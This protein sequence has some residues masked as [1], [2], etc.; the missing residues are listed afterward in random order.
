MGRDL[1]TIEIR[2]SVSNHHDA[3]DLADKALASQLIEE[4]AHVVEQ[5]K[6]QDLRILTSGL[7]PDFTAEREF[8]EHMRRELAVLTVDKQLPGGTVSV[9]VL[10]SADEVNKVIY[11]AWQAVQ[12][13]QAS[14]IT[15]TRLD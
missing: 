9:P 7:Q 3:R 11:A 1:F 2:Y 12:N 8:T 4:L 14:R 10:M 6:Y 15:D 13:W 5:S